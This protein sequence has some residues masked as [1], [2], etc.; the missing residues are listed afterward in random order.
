MHFRKHKSR[1]VQKDSD[2]SCTWQSKIGRIGSGSIKQYSIGK[3]QITPVEPKKERQPYQAD[4]QVYNYHGKTNAPGEERNKSVKLDSTLS[5]LAQPEPICGSVIGVDGFAFKKRQTYGT[6]IVDG[7]THSPIALLERRDTNSK[8][9]M[10][11]R[12]LYGRCSRQLL[13][14]KLMLNIPR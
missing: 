3:H 1:S 6:I 4:V 11:K 7:E 10:V 9:K 14:A 2:V 8:L 13:A 12:T 5:P